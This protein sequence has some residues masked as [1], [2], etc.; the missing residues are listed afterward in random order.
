MYQGKFDAKAKGQAS[1]GETLENILKERDAAIAAK[2]AKKARSAA[3]QPAAPKAAPKAAKQPAAAPK[4][5]KPAKEAR[6]PVEKEKA[7]VVEKVQAPKKSGPRMGG[8]IFYT[9][10]FLMILVFFVGV[11]GGLNW[12]NGWLKAYEEA[13]PTL[14]CQ[15]VFEQL[16]GDPDWAQLYSLAGVEDTDFE[17]VNEYVRYMENRVGDQDLNFVETSAGLS[18]NTKKYIVRLG[19]DKIGTFTLKGQ[20]EKVTDI[21]DWKLG[22]VELFINRTESFTVKKLEGHIAYVNGI[23]LDDSYTIQIASTKADEF[24]PTGAASVRTSIQC[25]SGLLTAP[26]FVVYDQTG[27]NRMEALYNPDSGMYEEQIGAIAITEEERSA[28][29]GALEAYAGFMINA[30]GS[31]TGVAKYFDGS[32]RVY[33]DIV[34]MNSELWMNADR[35]HEF[36]N[37]EILGYT[38]HSDDLFSVRA[39]MTMHVNNKDNTEKDYE[40]VESMFFTKKNGNW[41][42]YEMINQDITEPVGQVRLTFMDGSG[43]TL[44]SSFYETDIQMITTPSVTIPDGKVF[45]GWSKV[46]TGA[47][48]TKTWTIVFTPDANGNVYMNGTTALEPATL[49]PLFENA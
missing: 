31:R 36:R 24:L 13:Q 23:P 28:V 43:N 44:S 29:F 25:I 19:T 10:Y 3:S 1:P 37:E 5:A 12:L 15:E 33:S 6:R 41:V 7:V 46:E 40:V 49:Y 9:C 22:D 14:K 18:K 35:G 32:S 34:N 47:D 2:A 4:A 30:S 26:E 48:G 27:T 42:C 8:M 17:G 45:S 16:F 11:F 20:G 39:K 21:P 38:K